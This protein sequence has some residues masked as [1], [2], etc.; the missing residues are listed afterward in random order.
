MPVRV[1]AYELDA[2][3]IQVFGPRELEIPT[4]DEG[5]SKTFGNSLLTGC[6]LSSDVSNCPGRCLRMAAYSVSCWF[7]PQGENS[8]HTMIEYY[9]TV[10]PGKLLQ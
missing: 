9:N 10:G 8:E 3:P 6:R 7:L 4:M 2:L 5:I 1:H